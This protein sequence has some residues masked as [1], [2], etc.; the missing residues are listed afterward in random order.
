MTFGCPPFIG[1]LTN[2]ELCYCASPHKNSLYTIVIILKGFM[3][4]AEKYEIAK[5][6]IFRTLW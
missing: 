4:A 3:Q 1:T 5:T 2:T 6:E